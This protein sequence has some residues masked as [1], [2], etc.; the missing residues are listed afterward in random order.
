MDAAQWQLMLSEKCPDVTGESNS[1]L[2]KSRPHFFSIK[3]EIPG[4]LALSH[5]RFP[6]RHVSVKPNASGSVIAKPPNRSDCQQNSL[7]S[8]WPPDKCKKCASLSE[9]SR[10]KYSNAEAWWKDYQGLLQLQW[11]QFRHLSLRD[12]C[13]GARTPLP[14]TRWER[15][16]ERFSPQSHGIH[17]NWPPGKKKMIFVL[18]TVHP[19]SQEIFG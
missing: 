12:A 4:T 11:S 14:D 18:M 6:G 7:E 17:K 9:I 1:C 3:S 8:S 5:R 19:E 2:V 10:F 15:C 13:P 16:M